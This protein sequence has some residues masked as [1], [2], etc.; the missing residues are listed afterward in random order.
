MVAAF[1]KISAPYR[2][3]KSLIFL[4]SGKGHFARTNVGGQPRKTQGVGGRFPVEGG[5]KF[6]AIGI[7]VISDATTI[8]KPAD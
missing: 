1:L 3:N 6:H 7:F 4:D 5:V 8:D 2:R